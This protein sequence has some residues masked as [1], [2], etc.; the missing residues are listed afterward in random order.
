MNSFENYHSIINNESNYRL[1][2]VFVWSHSWYEFLFCLFLSL[3]NMVLC[4]KWSHS[5]KY[6]LAGGQ[7]S[8]W[9]IQNKTTLVYVPEGSLPTSRCYWAIFLLKKKW[10]LVRASD[11]GESSISDSVVHS[12]MYFTAIRLELLSRSRA[13]Q[14]VAYEVVS[15]F[16]HLRFLRGA[17]ESTVKMP[18]DVE[19]RMLLKIIT[20]NVHR[21]AWTSISAVWNSKFSWRGTVLKT[22]LVNQGI[23]KINNI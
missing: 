20:K 14:I 9:D 1:R 18:Q 17:M 5:E 13:N 23:I 15:S 4:R 2:V 22:V 8:L 21:N 3:L 11:R 19:E 7:G 16:I 6:H 12:C 10:L